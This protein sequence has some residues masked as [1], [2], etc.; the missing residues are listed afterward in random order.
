[1]PKFKKHIAVLFIVCFLSITTAP[2]VI[3][4]IDKS[5]DISMFYSFGEEDDSE[6]FKLTLKKTD[7][8]LKFENLNNINSKS[9]SY[10]ITKYQKPF[11]NLDSP[12]PD[13]LI[14]FMI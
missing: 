7:L 5:I 4:S 12:P 6:V 2:T 14:P 10:Q 8:E 1:M 3:L 11:L 9:S 13:D